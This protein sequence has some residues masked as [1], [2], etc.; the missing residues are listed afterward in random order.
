MQLLA[1][2]TSKQRVSIQVNGIVQGVGFRPYIYQL[3]LKHRLAGTVMNNGNGVLIDIEG[4]QADVANFL[5]EIEVSPP[6]LSRIDSIHIQ[7]LVFR[8]L[9]DFQIIASQQS[10]V[11][12][13]VSSDIAVCRPCQEEMCDPQNRRYRYPFI[14]CTDCGPR[15]SI[16]SKLPYDR[17]HTSM[18]I[19]DMCSTCKL[20]YNN[21][22]NRRY[23]AQPIGCYQCG[24]KLTLLKYDGTACKQDPI[25]RAV[26]LLK[27]GH[28]LA[29]KGLGGFHLMCDATNESAVAMLRK[30][31]HRPSKPFAV[32]FE[33]IKAVEKTAKLSAQEASLL[34]LKERPIVIVGK[35]EKSRSLAF[36]IAPNIDRI[37]VFL[38]Y[39]SIQILLLQ[40]LQ[41]PLVATSANMSEAPIIIDEQVLWKQLGDVANYVLT[42][43]R[44]IENACDDSVVMSLSQQTVMLRMGRGYAPKS[45]YLKRCCYRNIL[46]VGAHQKSTVTLAFGHYI[47]ISPHIGDLNS[48]EAMEYFERTVTTLCRLYRFTPDVI[49]CDTHPHYDTTQ[50]ARRYVATHT[51]VHLMQ[52]QHH[53]AHALA[54]MAEYALEEECLAF[55]FD[56]SGLGENEMLW[57]GEVLLVSPQEYK[58]LWHFK[59]LQLLG[60]D[61]AAKEPRRIAL[62]LLFEYYEL[63]VILQMSHPV[64]QSYTAEEIQ[65]YYQMFQQGLNTPKTSSLGRLFDA[66]YAFCGFTERLGYE[67][68]SGLVL[69]TLSRHVTTTQ[70][71]PYHLEDDGT[72]TYDA[73]VECMLNEVNTEEMALKFIN[74]VSMIIVDIAMRRP[75]LPII[76][77][78][79]V[80]QNGVLVSQVTEALQKR[81]RR[82]YM[83]QQT[84][85]NDG[86]ISLGQA[87]YAIHRSYND[88]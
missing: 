84:P 83:Q 18:R 29:V 63:D 64:V 68:E 24:P 59:E 48:I 51:Q 57:G 70:C 11:T 16:I 49:V 40:A 85:V 79:G 80:F 31:K 58:R 3:A 61:K 1:V 45:F 32:M 5:R 36:S 82:C 44:A 69:E 9:L 81:G 6:P 14:N 47:V 66:V 30:R 87:Y 72:I 88:A 52:V 76:L 21:P 2:S 26:Q 50:W 43:D 42:H 25:G 22:N 28:T 74:T 13:M 7:M 71:Y 75:H 77:S 23:H 27:E 12:T 35:R 8:G 54:C 10:D 20:E 78:G 39:T 41:R 56:G 46:A 60:G 73:M 19:F 37:G 15:Y 86:G 17:I 62:A 55:C 67:G 4:K 53:Y 65:A 33:N 34:C 38:P